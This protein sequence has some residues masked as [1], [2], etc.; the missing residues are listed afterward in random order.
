MMI[1]SKDEFQMLGREGWGCSCHG[2][3]HRTIT[4]ENAEY[5]LLQSRLMMEKTLEIPVK[6]FCLPGDNSHHQVVKDYAVKYG[7]HSI[8]TIYDR[9]NTDTTDLLSLGR[10]PLHTEYP[11]PFYSVYDPYKRIHQTIDLGGWL[12]DYCHC[13]MPDKPI[14]PAKD[15]TTQELEERFK[16]IRRIG[17]E[18]VWVAEPNEVA[19]YL[20]QK[21]K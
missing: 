2:M 17:G 1:L 13:P 12:I 16:T 20:L 21:R 10:C 8:L 6:M 15:C 4:P 5:E 7:Y 3:T 14:H 11:P 19:D 18:D 9:V